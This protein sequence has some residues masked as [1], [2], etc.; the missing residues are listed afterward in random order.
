MLDDSMGFSLMRW[1]T[2]DRAA[3]CGNRAR[4]RDVVGDWTTEGGQQFDW[5]DKQGI[6]A[7]ETGAD[8]GLGSA[9][10]SRWRTAGRH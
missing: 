2:R 9:K 5:L 1:K 8:F 4:W 10:R 3:V 7:Q 6:G